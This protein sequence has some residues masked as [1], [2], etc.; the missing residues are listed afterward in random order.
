MGNRWLRR[1]LLVSLIA[2]VVAN[3]FSLAKAFAGR[4]TGV[5]GTSTP[6]LAIDQEL[7]YDFGV[8]SLGERGS[9]SWTVRNTGQGDLELWLEKEPACGCTV[10]SLAKGQRQRIPPGGSMKIKLEWRTRKTNDVFAQSA[11]IATNDP[12]R[13]S[14]TLRISG[15][16][17]EPVVASPESVN[18]YPLY[19]GEAHRADVAVFS[20]DR[21]DFAISDIVSSRPDLIAVAM[22]PMTP[23]ESA[24]LRAK[25]GYRLGV[26]IKPGLPIGSLSETLVV[27]TNHPDRPTLNIRITGV[28]TGPISVAPSRLSI[29]IGEAQ[30]GASRGVML[31]VH[32]GRETRFDVL[33]KPGAVGVSIA[34]AAAPAGKRRYR[35]T[36]TASTKGKAAPEGEFI[37][38]KTD[39]PKVGVVTIPID[40]ATR[41]ADDYTVEPTSNATEAAR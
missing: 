15:R 32:D 7:S 26:E 8:A 4:P 34:P 9:H 37:T 31:L 20:P 2:G 28:V 5:G 12:G 29:P 19:N 35:L 1:S 40:F 14:F 22:K 6:A 24:N 16:A 27:H 13:P 25:A 39:H 21:S 30:E 36:V 3:P 18:F 38:V 10:A 33:H 41:R 17:Y 11:T 23:D